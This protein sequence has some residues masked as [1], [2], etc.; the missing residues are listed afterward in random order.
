MPTFSPKA[1][2][3]FACSSFS[4]LEKAPAA[5]AEEIKDAVLQ[6]IILKYISSVISN[7]RAFSA[8]NNS[9]SLI[10][11]TAVAKI[12]SILKSLLFNESNNPFDNK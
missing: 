10:S 9:P 4:L 11:L 2:N 3:N 5:H 6:R 8:C 1:L 12:S 7:L